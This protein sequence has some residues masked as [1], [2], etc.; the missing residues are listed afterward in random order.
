MRAMEAFDTAEEAVAYAVVR[1]A[2]M[3]RQ[4]PQK[5]AVQIIRDRRPEISARKPP[6]MMA[7][8]DQPSSPGAGT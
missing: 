3:R 7:T 8:V 2:T 1:I 6:A 4:A 5:P